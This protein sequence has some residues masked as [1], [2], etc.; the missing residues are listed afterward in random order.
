[1]RSRSEP[2]NHLA[3]MSH[4]RIFP[5]IIMVNDS[6]PKLQCPNCH[7]FW[8]AWSLRRERAEV[9]A[10]TRTQ[11]C[12][13]WKFKN[14]PLP[15]TNT[16]IIIMHDPTQPFCISQNLLYISKPTQLN[17]KDIRSAYMS[18]RNIE[19]GGNSKLQSYMYLQHLSVYLP[20]P[21]EFLQ[22]TSVHN[23]FP[24]NLVLPIWPG[25]GTLERNISKN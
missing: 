24:S 14:S 17:V 2:S 19:D 12:Y 6:T 8:Q 22:K 13:K 1:L 25:K 7:L 21:P 5:T 15:R 16:F 18:H 20:F 4:V 3:T 9:A 11:N 10:E 23:I